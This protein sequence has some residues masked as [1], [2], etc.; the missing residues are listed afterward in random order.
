MKGCDPDSSG[1]IGGVCGVYMMLMW[2]IAARGESFVHP[3]RLS[4]YFGLIIDR[5]V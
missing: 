1:V 4:I 5:T 3:R 2:S